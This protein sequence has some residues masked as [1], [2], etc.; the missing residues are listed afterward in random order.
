MS[1]SYKVTVCPDISVVSNVFRCGGL[2]LLMRGMHDQ[3]FKNFEVILVDNRYEKRHKKVMEW[4]K[5]YGL[6][7]FYHVPEYRRNG[8]WSVMAAGWDT[9]FMLAEAPVVI[10]LID[11][12]YAPAG[13]IERHLEH[14]YDRKSRLKKVFVMSPHCHVQM[15]PIWL[16]KPIADFQ[17]WVEKQ[18]RKRECCLIQENWE[19]YFDEMSIF[20]SI[21]EPE[22]LES[23]RIDQL[24]HQDPK[25]Y[26]S[27]YTTLWSAERGGQIAK[28]PPVDYKWMH[29]KNESFSLDTVLDVGGIDETFDNDKGPMDTEFG[30]RLQK[31]GCEVV[32]DRLNPVFI[33]NPRWIMGS[34]PWGDKDVRLEGRWSFNNDG[35]PYQD[36]RIKEM[37]E[38]APTVAQNSYSLR[39]K[40][41]E[42]LHWK[43]LDVVPTGN[44]DMG[45]KYAFLA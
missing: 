3:T 2:D 18:Q 35:I 30:F 5:H 10:M 27:S 38:G 45:G 42:L 33:P 17:A 37:S 8:K 26:L 28:M 41:K 21:F 16:K 7:R 6:E 29:M 13:W 34:M 31:S 19:E 15:P 32:F 44:L 4:A 12:A 11:Y 24:P 20:G 40:R 43:K 36:K 14:H 23:L 39:E 9:G 1:T 22:W 25:L